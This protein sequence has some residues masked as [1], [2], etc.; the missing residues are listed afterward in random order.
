MRASGYL[1]LYVASKSRA[2]PFERQ[3]GRQ[4]NGWMDGWVDKRKNERED[5]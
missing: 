3:A 1:L 4:M 2:A 5:E